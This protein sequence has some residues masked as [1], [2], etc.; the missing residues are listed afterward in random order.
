MQYEIRDDVIFAF[1][2]YIGVGEAPTSGAIE[3]PYTIIEP[4][5]CAILASRVFAALSALEE[6]KQFQRIQKLFCGVK[7][8]M[9]TAKL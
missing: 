3:H 5:V 7:I 1:N 9:G 2:N 6:Q 4:K 8:L